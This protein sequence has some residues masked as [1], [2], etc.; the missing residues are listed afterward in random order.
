[1]KPFVHLHVHSQYS[2]LDGADTCST[3]VA[4]A[5][6]CGLPA[7]AITDHNNVSAAVELSKAAREYGIKPIHGVEVSM[8]DGSHLTLLAQNPEGYSNI[9]RMLTEAHMSSPRRQPYANM[10]VLVRHAEGIVALSGCN[11]HGKIPMLVASGRFNEAKATAE[12][13]A[14]IFGKENFHIELE[15]PLTPGA[16]SINAALAELARKIG[17]GPVATNNVHYA[18]KS[19]FEIHDVLTCVRTLTS[20]DDIHPERRI[21]AE[22]Y[23]K[24]AD[25]MY[26]LFAGYPEALANT[27]EIAEKC[28]PGLELSLRLFPKYQAPQGLSSAQYLRRLTREGAIAR[29]GKITSMIESRLGHELGIITALGFEDYFL[30]VWDIARWARSQGIRYAGRGSAADSAVA[31]CLKLT[32]VDSIARGLLFE[33]FMSLERAQKPDID[34]DFESARR[35]DVAD[36]VYRKYGDGHVASVCTF[37]TFQARSAVRDFG[38]AL[39]F[40]PDDIDSIARILPHIPADAVRSALKRYPEARDAQIPEWKYE[41][42]FELCESVAGFPRHIGTHLGGLVISDQPLTCVTPLQMSAKGIAITQFDKDT[43]EDLGLIKL[44]LLS[45]RTLSAVEHAVDMVRTSDKEHADFDYN[46]IPLDDDDTYAMLN[47]G[48]TIGVFQLE[49]P[50]QRALQTRLEADNIEDIVASVALIRP[51]PIQGNMVEP[52]IARRSGSEEITYIHPKLEPILKKTYGVVLYQE[53]VIEI[54]TVI[55]GF[56]P[57][58]ADRLRKVM[59]HFRSMREMEDIGRDFVAKAVANGVAPDIAETIFSYILGYAGYGFCEAHA[60]AFADTAYKTAYLARHYPAQFYAALLSTQPMGFYPART[61]L[62]EAKR[63]GVTALPLD[64]NR[65][66][67]KFSVEGEALRVGLMQVSG[68]SSDLVREIVKSREDDGPFRS[69]LDFLCRI[70]ANKGVIENLVLAGAFDS[71]DPNRKALFWNLGRLAGIAASRRATVDAGRTYGQASLL[72][73]ERPFID[74]K[75]Y[76]GYSSENLPDFS[77]WEKFKHETS[78]LGFCTSQHAMEFFRPVLA[79]GGIWDSRRIPSAKQGQVVRAAGLVVRPHRP[80]TKSGKTVVFLSLEDEYGLTDVTV[81]DNV[82]QKQG[83][84]IFNNPALI[85]VGTISRRGDG[86]SVIA[87]SIESL[88]KRSSRK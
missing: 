39:G 49:S 67:E 5:A 1:M 12:N 47:R 58:E 59:T 25:E 53:Q 78:V 88:G 32:N 50:A 81:F 14:S 52:F 30:A 10:E 74:P 82:Y 66:Q 43:I 46:G 85:V 23:L 55:A 9:C 73:A 38:K 77:A 54:A 24:S 21:N 76:M 62:V 64:I 87:K 37:N 15:N 36:Y 26:E 83:T 3:L 34:I 13:L 68:I 57:G 28:S 31:Y 2:F 22:N 16:A 65:S 79:R 11:R 80:P 41:L 56:T 40:P 18:R 44:D 84:V 72:N 6:E 61:L 27:N 69:A 4:R 29:Y 63:R 70:K 33:R 45:L 42:L 51:G 75:A 60:A 19:R 71:T 20:L 8:S 17:V 86:V 7:I 48:E 35:D